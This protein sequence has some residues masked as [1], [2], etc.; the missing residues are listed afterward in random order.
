MSG[1]PDGGVPE[2][3]AVIIENAV[4]W[5]DAAPGYTAAGYLLEQ[6]G[7][8]PLAADTD[9]DGLSDEVE[10]VTENTDPFFEDSDRDGLSDGE[11]VKQHH[12]NPK[13]A[14]SDGDGLS[15]RAELV[16]LHTNPNRA[17]SDDDGFSDLFEINTGFNPNLATS[18]PD[19]ISSIKTAIE[20][21]FN[22]A[23]GVSYRIEQSTDLENWST[24][25]TDIMG[26]GDVVTRYYPTRNQATRY[27]RP[28]RN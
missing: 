1:Q 20:F 2:S 12:T 28:R 18:S 9:S 24:I 17:D 27:F 11:E 21:S 19:A 13:S 15:D 16:E 22:A 10:V 3:G 26:A 4:T 8:N 25:E 23:N 7:L 5:A 14:D 6:V